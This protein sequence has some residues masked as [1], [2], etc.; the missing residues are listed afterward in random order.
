MKFTK[1]TI[2]HLELCY[3]MANLKY[4]GKHCFLVA[5][6]KHAPCH[7][8]T[9]EGELIGTPW[10]EPGGVMT[11]QQI[12]GTDGQFLATHKFYSPNDSKEAKIVTCTPDGDGGWIVRTLLD[13]PFVHRFGILE[14]NGVHYLI[15]CCLKSDHEYKEDWRFPGAVY[16]AVLPKDVSGLDEK[17]Q[18]PV[19]KIKDGMLKNH[20]FCMTDFDGQRHAIVTCE[21]GVF[22]FT[23]PESPE[24]A[25][26]IKQ[27]LDMP[28]SDAVLCDFDGDGELELG[29]IEKFHGDTLSIFHLNGDGVYKKCWEYGEKLEFLHAIWAG[30]LC[31]KNTFVVGNRRGNRVTMAVT[32]ENGAYKTDIIERDAGAANL[33]HFMNAQGKDVLVAANREISEVAMFTFEP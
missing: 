22:L 2:S 28:V 3:A 1:K 23:P 6:E 32:W 17:H 29:T 12:P 25:W 24:R 16:A 8:F 4:Q 18:L 20:G 15:V 21:E 26:E 11:M 10:T 7:L 27:L 9:E 33:L 14:R 30:K 31:G 19:K 5:A 13:A